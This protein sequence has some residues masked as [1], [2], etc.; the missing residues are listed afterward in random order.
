M[1]AKIDFWFTM[2]S[3]YTYLAVMRLLDVEQ[4]TGIIFR[5]RPF[6]L[7]NILQEMNYTPFTDKPAKQAYMWRDIERRAAMYGIPA[8]TPV[9]YPIRDGGLSNRIA[10][11]GIEEGWGND[12]IR[13]SYERWFTRGEP[14]GREPNVSASLHYIGQDPDRVMKLANSDERNQTLERE[15][16]IAKELGIFGSPTFAIDKELFWGD[17]RLEDA[18]AWCRHGRLMGSDR[19]ALASKSGNGPHLRHKRPGS[20]CSSGR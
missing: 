20:G 5:R 13:A 7:I 9:P 4:S 10:S 11:L 6:Y 8:R 15:T 12:F 3:T 17:D 16:S 14:N 2:A 1:V 19:P 18:I